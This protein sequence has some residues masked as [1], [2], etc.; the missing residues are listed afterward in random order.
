MILYLLSGIIQSDKNEFQISIKGN[1]DDI[2]P[3]KFSDQFKTY[4]ENENMFLMPLIIQ[5]RKGNDVYIWTDWAEAKSDL[6]DQF[7]ERFQLTIGDR[8][9]Q[10]ANEIC[11]QTNEFNLRIIIS[12]DIPDQWI[13]QLSHRFSAG[14]QVSIT[15]G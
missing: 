4:T 1:Y 6:D 12:S 11:R 7:Q 10:A 2:Y 13:S 15:K 5:F 8:F 14:F 9:F 3:I